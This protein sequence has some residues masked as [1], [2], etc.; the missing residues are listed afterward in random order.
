MIG[1]NG[2]TLDRQGRLVIATWAGRSIDRIENNGK[3]TDARRP[4][5]WQALWRHQ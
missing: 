1:C 5:G 2:L 3:R 4:L